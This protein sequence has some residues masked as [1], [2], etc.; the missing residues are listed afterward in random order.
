M[1]GT[2]TYRA[3]ELVLEVKR[4]SYNPEAYPLDDWERYIDILCQNREYQKEAI[5]TAIIYLI[6][7]KYKTIEDLVEENYQHN[8]KLVE[9]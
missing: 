5:K 7:E 2:K 1:K 4:N 9:K 3:S 6:T 8:L